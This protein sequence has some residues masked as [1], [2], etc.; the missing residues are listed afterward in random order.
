[1]IGM[2]INVVDRT[3]S[4]SRLSWSCY[5]CYCYW[6]IYTQCCNGKDNLPKM[7]KHCYFYFH[8]TM[9]RQM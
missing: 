1:M 5:H 6:C 4:A 3:D 9:E 8:T 2:I 7:T